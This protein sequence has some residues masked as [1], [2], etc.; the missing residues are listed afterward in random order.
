MYSFDQL[1]RGI[2]HP[3]QIGREL[4]RIYYKYNDPR[5]SEPLARNFLDEDWDNLIILDACRYDSFLRCA[6]LTGE[7][8]HRYSLG[9]TT[10]EFIKTNFSGRKLYDTV[11]V[12]ANT[13]LL[14]L[15][16]EI[17]AEIHYFVDLQN[18][19]YD[20]SWVSEELKVV[21]PE[22][23]T[24]YAKLFNEKYPNKR[25]II[26]YLQPHHPFIG[27]TGKKYLSHQSNSLM[28]VVREADAEVDEDRVREAYDENLG[29]VLEEV[30]NLIPELTGKT[31]VAADHGEML[32]DRY[33]VVPTRDYGH[34]YGI[35]T[36]ILTKVP[37]NIIDSG[38]RK[39]I[40]EE[41]PE[42][43]QQHDMARVNQHLRDLGYVVE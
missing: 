24:H 16:D 15:K 1:Y 27:P 6:D 12:G 36:D 42:H 37:W 22:T 31:V 10:F 2:R 33:E 4:N 5:K 14:K 29:L 23:V 43:D 34:P 25:L 17:N 41:E 8:E 3:Q 18:G 39:K 32:G 11:Y 30:S 13:W 35:Y 7:L 28:E 20:V 26:H 9:S 38:E 21:S 19:K 40:I